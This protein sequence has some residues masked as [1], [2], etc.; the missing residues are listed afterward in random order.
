M[1]YEQLF[2]DETRAYIDR[3][4]AHFGG[5]RGKAVASIVRA[6]LDRERNPNRLWAELEARMRHRPGSRIFSLRVGE[7]GTAAP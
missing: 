2:D 7:P 6:A 4:A 1:E 3:E 5:D